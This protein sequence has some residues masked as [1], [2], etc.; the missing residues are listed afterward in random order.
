MRQISF[1]LTKLQVK[2]REK[3]VTRRLGWKNLMAG[4]VLQGVEQGQGIPKGG[5]VKYLPQVLV[6]SVRLEPLSAIRDEPNGT[7]L[8]GFPEMSVDAFIE[9]FCKTHGGCTPDTVVTRIEFEYLDTV[10][11]RRSA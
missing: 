2:R 1:K 9:M 4:E 6:T 3:T 11:A 8:E 5:R 10:P 7:A